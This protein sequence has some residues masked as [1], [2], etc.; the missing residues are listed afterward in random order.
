MSNGKRK[1]VRCA[2]CCYLRATCF[3]LLCLTFLCICNLFFAAFDIQRRRQTLATAK[4]MKKEHHASVPR[5]ITNCTR[6]V[7]ARTRTQATH[8]K[9]NT[10]SSIGIAVGADIKLLER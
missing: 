3:M 6:K 1:A 10:F 8:E 2:V 7:I 4:T 9:K 5:S